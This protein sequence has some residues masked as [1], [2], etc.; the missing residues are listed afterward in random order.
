[1]MRSR[2]ITALALSLFAAACAT[3]GS[4]ARDPG[5]IIPPQMVTRAPMP[6]LRFTSGPGGV[7]LTADIQ[8]VIGSTGAPDMSTFRATGSATVGN[9][10]QLYEWVQSSTFKPA[11]R[12]GQPVSAIWH[13]HMQF[14]LEGR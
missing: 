9:H 14:R 11:L 5:R 13:N 7:P 2:A 10:D 1:M 12:D 4:T 6:L 8:V 3:A